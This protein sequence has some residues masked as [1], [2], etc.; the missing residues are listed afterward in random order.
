MEKEMNY[1]SQKKDFIIGFD[2]TVS[3]FPLLLLMCSCST[4]NP[5]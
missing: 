4:L 5:A 3:F 2:L 1:N